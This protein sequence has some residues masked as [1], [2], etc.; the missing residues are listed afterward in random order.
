[1]GE[2]TPPFPAGKRVVFEI[3]GGESDGRVFDSQDVEAAIG[4]MAGHLWFATGGGA[5]GREFKGR[6]IA[7]SDR[8][9]RSLTGRADDPY[10]A[11]EER[12]FVVGTRTDDGETIRVT[13]LDVTK[14]G[15]T[16]Q[17]LDG[18]LMP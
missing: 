1:M 6:S 14:A 3:E 16:G 13:L 9:A 7:G 12:R 5:E 8:I 18:K 2:S 17:P 4:M 10:A 11:D 15:V